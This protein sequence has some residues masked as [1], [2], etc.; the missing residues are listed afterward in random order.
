MQNSFRISAIAVMVAML[1]AAPASALTLNLGGTGSGGLVN[2]GGSNTDPT[3]DVLTNGAAGGTPTGTASTNALNNGGSPTT[4]NVTLGGAGAG[5]TNGNVLLDLF[6]AGNGN[7]AAVALGSGSGAN[8]GAAVDLFGTGETGG[9][10]GTGG[11]GSG[12]DLFGPPGGNGG[13]GGTRVANGIRTASLD[14]VGRTRCFAPDATQIARLTNRH[15]YDAATLSRWVDGASVSIVDT[16]LCDS[17][18]TAIAR[19]PNVAQLQSF[20]M[21]NDAIKSMLAKQGRSARDVIAI[22]KKDGTLV[23][24]VS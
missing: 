9:G 8:S 21:A 17:A 10:A 18:R 4:A 12:G 22:D 13:P 7:E 3:V 23:V 19:D 2:V 1:T 14:N 5:N 6:G 11:T 15:A 24:Y 20:V 16:G